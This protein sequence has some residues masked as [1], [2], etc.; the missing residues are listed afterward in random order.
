MNSYDDYVI[1]LS[2][3]DLAVNPLSFQTPSPIRFHDKVKEQDIVFIRK[4][5]NFLLAFRSMRMQICM[6]LNI[7][8]VAAG[9]GVRNSN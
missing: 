4:L 7:S 9:C 8:N 3:L 1:N 5:E 2:L 6:I